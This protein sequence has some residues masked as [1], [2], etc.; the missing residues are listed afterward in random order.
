MKQP[1]DP[2]MVGSMEDTV[3]E[4]ANKTPEAKKLGQSL[5]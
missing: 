2:Q 3:A 1:A 4:R 5:D